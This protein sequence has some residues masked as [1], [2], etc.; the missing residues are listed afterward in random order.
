MNGIYTD[1]EN[2][3]VVFSYLIFNVASINKKY[4]SLSKFINDFEL[5]GETN[6]KLYIL[7]EMVEPHHHLHDLIYENLKWIGF[8]EKEDFVFGFEHL[9]KGVKGHGPENINREI[10]ELKNINWLGSYITHNGNYVWY[11]DD[12][13]KNSFLSYQE[14][15][16][17]GT[18]PKLYYQN[19]L[20]VYFKYLRNPLKFK[21]TKVD[22]H[23]VYFSN[24]DN[25]FVNGIRRSTLERYKKY[26]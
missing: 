7:A 20:T 16:L 17:E 15:I 12:I 11:V 19:L 5:W 25:P 22:D 21:I 18:P 6:G 10:P 9:T 3:K 2:L 4:G 14:N 23:Y 8:K 13:K 1:K 26:T 24:L